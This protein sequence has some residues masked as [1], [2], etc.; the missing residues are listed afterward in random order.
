LHLAIVVCAAEP[1]PVDFVEVVGLQDGGR[2]D[3]RAR[4]GLEVERHA[5][6]EEVPVGLDGRVVAGFTDGELRACRCVL[7]VPCGDLPGIVVGARCCEVMGV[8]AGRETCV[9]GTC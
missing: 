9:V 7:H 1:F 4:G 8:C 5:P 2:D 6:E 3:A